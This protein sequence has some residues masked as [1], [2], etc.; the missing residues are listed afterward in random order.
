M[1]ISNAPLLDIDTR[2]I[3][4][5]NDKEILVAKKDPLLV[6]MADEKK[7]QKEKEQEEKKAEASQKRSR[8][9]ELSEDEKRVVKELASR[10]A[11]VK[12]HEAAHQASGSGMT[13]AASYT[14][15][16]GPDGKMYA[17]GGEVSISTPAASSPEEAIK[18]ARQVATSAMA[19]GNPSPQD[20]AVAASA[21]MMEIKAQQE[22]AQE[23][24]KK[25]SGLK[26]Y[27]DAQNGLQMRQEE[28]PLLD[29]P[30]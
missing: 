1:N 12:A 23:E 5:L 24:Q 22:L 18:I 19:A 4:R 2:F 20:F 25:L 17:I 21:R 15:Q 13:G 11:E 14:H 7:A 10:D 8:P 9:N 28:T 3:S 16:R 27:E 26:S 29:I 30:A 6:S